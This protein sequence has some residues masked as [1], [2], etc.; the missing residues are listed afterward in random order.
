MADRFPHGLQQVADAAG[1]EAALTLA[2]ACAG[3]RLRVPQRAEGSDLAAIVGIDAAAKIV[4]HLADERIEI[5]QAKRILSKWLRG[6]GWS[7]E[8]VANTLRVARRT[9]QYWDTGTTPSMQSDL[10]S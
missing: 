7:Q 8:R 5:P 9:V 3:R 1:D 4:E 10:F 6:R 2:L